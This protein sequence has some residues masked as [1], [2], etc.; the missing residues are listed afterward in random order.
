MGHGFKYSAWR[1]QQEMRM[2]V[3]SYIRS[4]MMKMMMMIRIII[5]NVLFSHTYDN[6]GNDNRNGPIAAT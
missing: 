6:Y 5:K 1:K 3:M 4:K 2:I